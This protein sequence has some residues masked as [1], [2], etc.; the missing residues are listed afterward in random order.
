M[1]VTRYLIIETTSND[2]FI[3]KIHAS[4][5]NLK[6]P[7]FYSKHKSASIETYSSKEMGLLDSCNQVVNWIAFYREERRP[8]D[9]F[10]QKSDL[11]GDV[12]YVRAKRTEDRSRRWTWRDFSPFS[13]YHLCC[14]CCTWWGKLNWIKRYLGAKRFHCHPILFTNFENIVFQ[15]FYLLI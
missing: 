3:L 2:L 14:F 8:T 9:F 4:K 5:T 1:F 7:D 10:L 12:H 6:M 11:I 15:I 13:V